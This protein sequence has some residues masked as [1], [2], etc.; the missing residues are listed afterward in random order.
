MHR[1]WRAGFGLLTACLLLVPSFV[2]AETSAPFEDDGTV[3]FFVTRD[4]ELA[5]GLNVTVSDIDIQAYQSNGKV[6]NKAQL[7]GAPVTASAGWPELPIISKVVLV[8]PTSGVHLKLKNIDYH[9]ENDFEPFIVPEYDSKSVYGE[10]PGEPSN[11]FLS[12]DGF[13]PPEPVN[14]SEPAILRGHRLVSV[15]VFPIQYNPLTHE[16]RFNDNVDFELVYEG[17]GVNPVLN[18]EKP[19]TSIYAI[20]ALQALAVNPPE[21]SRDDWLSGSYLYIVPRVNGVDAALAPLI[22]WRKRQGHRVV[23]EHVDNNASANTIGNLIE[24]AYEEWEDPVEFVTLVGDAGGTIGLTAASNISDYNYTRVDGNDPLPDV[25]LGRLS[26]GSANELSR[27]VEKIVTYESDPQMEDPD[28]FLHG[29]VV[30]GH[31]G[32]GLGTVLVAKYVRKELLAEGF[33]EVRHW[34]HTED[35]EIQNPQNFV[36]DAFEWGISIFHYRAYQAMNQMPINDILGLDNE[37]GPWPP[38]LAISCNTGDFVGSGVTGRTE[39]F[40]RAEGG[41][42]GAIGT[43]TPGTNVA[44]NNM[45]AGGVWKGIYKSKLYA[46]GWGLNTGKYELWKAYDGFD[47]RYM[48]FMEWNNLMGDAGSHIWTGLPIE[49]IVT[50]PEAIAIGESHFAVLVE[51]AEEE[52]AMPDALVCLYKEDEL[53][54]TAFTN[55]D[56]I[57]EFHIPPDAM[58]EGDL[59]VTVT[60]HNVLP[61]LGEASVDEREMYLGISD[62]FV[63]ENDA[64]PNPGAQIDI[65]VN[66]TNFGSSVPEGNVTLSAQSLS[67][68]A[69]V[70]S[71]P[72]EFNGAPEVDESFEATIT[73]A[74]DNSAPD[75]EPILIGFEATTGANTWYSNIEL[76]TESPK[77]EVIDV[78]IEGGGLQRAQVKNFDLELANTG[79]F[80]IEHFN[81][82]IWC[83]SDV[84][85][86]VNAEVTYPAID[87]GHTNVADNGQ[88]RISAHPFSV[89][90][91]QVKI[92]MA[93]EDER[94]FRDTTSFNV[95]L[96]SPNAI[97]PFGP[98]KYGY[99]CFDSED[100]G[101][102]MAPVYDWIEIYSGEENNDFDGIDTELRD[103]GDNQDRSLTVEIPF[104]FQYYGKVFNELTICTNGWAALGNQAEL[105]D[106]RNRQIGQA[107]GP[108][109][110]LAVFWDNLGTSGNDSK[111]LYYY[112]ED[113]GRFIVEWHLAR[114]LWDRTV[115]GEWETFELI[116]YDVRHHPTYSNDGTIVYQYKDVRNGATPAHSD[117][118]YC[119]IGISN[120]DDSDGLQYTYYNRFTPGATPL[121]NELAIKFTTATEFITGIL[122]GRVTD[123]RSGEPIEGA[124]IITSRGFWAITD[125]N[126]EYSI[127]E[128]LI[129]ENYGVTASAQGYNDSLKMGEDGM[130][131]TIIEDQTTTVDF[132]LLH[133][134]FNV[135]VEQ[136]TYQLMQDSTVETGM[137]LSNDGN[138]TLWF[139]SKYVYLLNN[140][141]EQDEPWGDPLLMW[142]VSEV[143]EDLRIRSI[144]YIGEQWFV[145]GSNNGSDTENYFYIFDRWGEYVDRIQQPID[146]YGVRDM[147]YFDGYIYATSSTNAIHKINPENGELVYS[148]EAPGNSLTNL[149]VSTDGHIWTADM[150]NYLFE[151][152]ERPDSTLE[153]IQSFGALLNPS[154]GERVR[155]NGLAWFRDDPDGFNLY[156]YTNDEM[157]DDSDHPD[158]LVYKFNPRTGE[159]RIVTDFPG[160]DRN[161]QGRLGCTITPKWNNLVWV[162]AAAIDNPGGDK[163]AVFELAP[164]SSWIDYS[165]RA[166]TLYATEDTTVSITINTT[167]LDWGEY[168]V[169]IEF[170]HNADDGVMRLPID[171]EVGPF[172]IPGDEEELPLEY[173]LD[174]NWPNPFNPSTGISYS[175]KESGLVTLQVFDMTGRKIA[176]LV[177]QD[178]PAGNY[179]ITFDGDNL[180]AGLYFYRLE[181]G[182]FTSTKKMVLM[183]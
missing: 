114:R 142:N 30:A 89:P 3:T 109:A 73:V 18:P 156:L 162:F 153:L 9:I 98:D 94:G 128:I 99:V 34:Y 174:Q 57:A 1:A 181:A 171:L 60:K 119:T 175:L 81:A 45:M 101:W 120:L 4:D 20:R 130:G 91:M 102:E 50:H 170:K 6:F 14:V 176:D 84:V 90:G 159:V 82:V 97:D 131:Y 37:D 106:F 12:I 29:A 85:N 19:K 92:W 51:D 169:V 140:R 113:G 72:F 26:C 42:I 147:Q 145:A 8:P 13:W 132:A 148:L 22:E 125:E 108:N 61:Y 137:N 25:A 55:E 24:E 48:D 127:D 167:D 182:A 100:E 95:T 165:P 155:R 173:T 135:D 129:G 183:K 87:P 154:N 122:N 160:L 124:E 32:N 41:G 107:L 93:V 38:V 151:M 103:G 49:F 40:L 178:Q 134:E 28:W 118:P 138:G 16:T 44:Y 96:G 69:E 133:P 149:A 139:N 158:I 80:R 88:L 71:E 78:N 15:N 36:F 58:S 76:I 79:S 157:E 141:D 150:S 54:L 10:V 62:D 33:T 180:P 105:Q 74:L 5:T 111:I 31:V 177:D 65:T 110:Q 144:A 168:G 66:L 164:N 11:E 161:D 7:E 21:P 70:I 77:I 23:V 146:G 163:I 86:P 52:V 115:T 63:F 166:D 179:R 152:V 2:N 43:C 27:I 75:Q 47:G 104:D 172:A 83:D 143:T 46:F 116:L 123:A 59:M 126:G 68:W 121:R 39:A 53:H 17:E 67:E 56:G 136:F 112:D 35:N 117:T 64:A